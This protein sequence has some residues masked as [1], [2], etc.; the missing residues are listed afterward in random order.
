[1]FLHW[2]ALVVGLQAGAEPQVLDAFQYAAP[3]AAR[4]EWV[5]G[6]GTPAVELVQDRGRGVLQVIAPFG[7]Q[8]DLKRVF[9]DRKVKLDLAVPGQFTLELCID[10]PDAIRQVSLYFRSG[11]G[12]YA[13]GKGLSQK[14][15]HTLRFSKADFRTEDQPAG[16]QK[17]DGIRLAFWPARAVDA[18]VRLGRLAASWHDVALV[19]PAGG[20]QAKG[21]ERR[22][23][24][25]A[26]NRVVAMLAE[27][28]LGADAVEDSALAGGVLGS[29]RVAILPYNPGLP[30]EAAQALVRFVEAGGKV[31]ACYGLE[32][33]LGKA[34]G[35]GRGQYFRPERTG[36][37]AEIRFEASDIPGLPKTVRQASWNIQTAQPAGF[38]A[39]VIGRWYD[40]AG[41]PTGQPAMLLSDRGAY[42]SHLF[43]ADDPEGKRQ[44][45]AA[46]L[47]KLDPP[48][49]R[50]MARAEQD[51]LGRVGH[52]IDLAGLTA[53]IKENANAAASQRLQ[54]ALGAAAAAKARFDQQDYQAAVDEARQAHAL[55][56]EAYLRA[57]PCPAREGRA[58]W[59]HSGT[60]AYPGDWER[61]AGELARAGF[62]MILPNMLWGGRA[63]YP[64]DVLPRSS[65]FD[66]YGDQ[67]AQCVAAARKHGLEVHVW[68]VNWNLSNAS[69]EFVA[70]MR[71][72]GRTQVSNQGQP[73]DWLCPSHPENFKLE[74][75]SMLEVARN[76]DVDG[77]H[78]DY[79]RYPGPQ[80]CYCDGC[81]QRFEE[82]TGR[83]V[84]QW[85]KDCVSGPLHDAYQTWRRAQITRLV[86][87]VHREAKKLKPGIQ[88]S[89][90][91]FGSYP[92]CL[93]SV[94]QDWVSWIKAGYLDFVC[95]MDYSDSD[96]AFSGLVANQVKLVEGRIPIYPGIGATSS[97]STLTA[98]RVVGQIH[99][100]RSL[101]AAGFTIFNFHEGTARDVLPGVAQGATARPAVPPHREK[102]R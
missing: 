84:A 99:L 49:W 32:P 76:Y 61:S 53:Y 24:Q 69:P 59:N 36:G 58:W 8:P 17:V 41:R 78:F 68:K 44:L 21:S 22:T 40:D 27:L 4:T 74:L 35:F 34:L 89:A 94:G 51:R 86:E 46:V 97:H 88:I 70:Q 92:G 55:L 64:S 31:F 90:A 28:G 52:C 93:E 81:R 13:A 91:V 60:G 25:E 42:L 50:E 48:L 26:A 11:K 79:I 80:F 96:T 62:N 71:R 45:L 9:I 16:W 30:A 43:L 1:M 98:D 29:R 85:P 6:A 102:G 65:T 37:L 100:A 15:W 7:A 3:E 72:Q 19:V 54:A 87:A 5:A 33:R 82:Q 66:Q 101:G 83:K 2:L 56:V 20:K 75:E 39:R 14:G 38:G 67:I 57:Q 77:L 47:G 63:H 18:S 73:Q 10:P 12:W 95:P 23:A